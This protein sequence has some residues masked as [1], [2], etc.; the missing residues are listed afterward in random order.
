MSSADLRFAE[1]IDGLLASP[2]RLRRLQ[3][4]APGYRRTCRSRWEEFLALPDGLSLTEASKRL[5]CDPRQV[6]R[7]RRR[8]GRAQPA[9]QPHPAEHRE[10]AARLI[11]DGCP[12]SEVARTVNATHKTIRHWFPD[13]PAWTPQEAGALR[14]ALGGF[15]GLPANRRYGRKAS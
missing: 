9:V 5:G 3:R 10:L 4:E 11:E 2:I 13:A 14:R 6:S 8:A 7:Y 12:I 1:F 15:E